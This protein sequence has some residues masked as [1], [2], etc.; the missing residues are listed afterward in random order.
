[1][2]FKFRSI[3]DI[4]FQSTA[5]I[6]PLAQLLRSIGNAYKGFKIG[7][8]G[9]WIFQSVPERSGNDRK[10]NYIVGNWERLLMNIQPFN[11]QSHNFNDTHTRTHAH[12]HTHTM[13]Y[14]ASSS[15]W[16]IYIPVV[17]SLRHIIL[18]PLS[19]LPPGQNVHHF[20]GSIGSG[21]GFAPSRRQA[22][23]WTNVDP[24]LWRIY[25]ALRGRMS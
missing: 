6:Y 14:V 15:Y 18:I 21:N 12:T 22:M 16:Y 17:C 13:G 2:S 3:E 20:A 7:K 5:H 1:M 9:G 11:Y 19:H 4:S 24:V 8:Y 23:T 10:R 25:A